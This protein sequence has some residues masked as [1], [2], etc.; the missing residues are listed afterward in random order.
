MGTEWDT[1]TSKYKMFCAAH[2]KQHKSGETITLESDYTW[3]P[4]NPTR[5]GKKITALSLDVMDVAT[6]ST[7]SVAVDPAFVEAMV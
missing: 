1:N 7:K 5:D 2:F 6:G 4:A 3:R